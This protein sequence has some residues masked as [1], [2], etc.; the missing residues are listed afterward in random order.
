MAEAAAAVAGWSFPLCAH[1]CTAALSTAG[2]LPLTPSLCVCVCLCVCVSVCV[3][4]RLHAEI[5]V[6][7][8]VHA[9][10]IF[11]LSSSCFSLSISSSRASL[12]PWSSEMCRQHT[13][14]SSLQHT[15]THTQRYITLP[16]HTHTHTHTHTRARAQTHI[17]Y[18]HR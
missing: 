9:F 11:H 2:F 8:C 13:L 15:H 3:S 1:F 16:T 14:S 7:F 4:M 10:V 12:S 18:T 5:A 6:S 17:T